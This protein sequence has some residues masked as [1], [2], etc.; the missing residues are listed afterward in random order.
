M[1]DQRKAPAQGQRT[2]V[3]IGITYRDLEEQENLGNCKKPQ[4]NTQ[5]KLYLW[6]SLNTLSGSS[7]YWG[8]QLLLFVYP[9]GLLSFRSFLGRLHFIC[10]LYLNLP[11]SLRVGNTCLKEIKTQCSTFFSILIFLLSINSAMFS[12]EE[13]I[14]ISNYFLPST[15]EDQ[16]TVLQQQL[17]TLRSLTGC[18]SALNTA[19]CKK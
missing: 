2:S 14:D 10:F 18:E 8:E 3:F 19:H 9:P 7:A 16:A 5:G 1:T 17:S 12:V 11:S 6:C 4:P 13:I 15:T